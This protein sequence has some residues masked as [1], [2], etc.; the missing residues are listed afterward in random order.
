MR[1]KKLYLFLTCLLMF[2]ATVPAEAM[3]YTVTL[4]LMRDSEVLWTAILELESDG[5]TVN[6]GVPQML[7]ETIVAL[8]G[9][10]TFTM[11]FEVTLDPFTL[12]VESDPP[13]FTI[14]FQSISQGDI[15]C[16][17]K[18]DIRD[19]ALVAIHYGGSAESS[20][21]DMFSDSNM[22]FK[23]DIVDIATVAVKFGA[24]Y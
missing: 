8:F 24:T 13:G 10:D 15:N 19:I 23:I 4:T 20:N 22:D 17:K 3:T 12:R 5:D 14:I 6:L 18:V 21:Y 9:T 11:P 1:L 7:Y 16:D 2:V